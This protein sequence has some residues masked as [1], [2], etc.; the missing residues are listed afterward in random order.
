MTAYKYCLYNFFFFNVIYF[1]AG[2]REF[3]LCD[4]ACFMYGSDIRFVPDDWDSVCITLEASVQDIFVHHFLFMFHR[5]DDIF[6]NDRIGV[7][8]VEN[9]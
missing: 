5:R 6:H 2:N 8:H 7:P 3:S 9:P 1:F 4:R